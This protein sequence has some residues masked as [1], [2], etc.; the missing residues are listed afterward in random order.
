MRV[1]YHSA[2][3]S[4]ELVAGRALSV[5]PTQASLELR[6]D[7]DETSYQLRYNGVSID[8]DTRELP[9]EGRAELMVARAG[10]RDVYSIYPSF[11]LLSSKYAKAYA[12]FSHDF[13]GLSS[14]VV[15][16]I[17]RGRI[18]LYALDQSAEVRDYSG[19]FD[20]IEASF[21]AFKAICERP[22]SHLKS[23][24]EIRPIDAVKRVGYESIPYLAAHS[25]D[26]LARTASGLKPARLF[27]R[28]EED[29]FHIYENRLVKTLIDLVLAFLRKVE[30]ELR[31]QRDQLKGILDS[32]V[33]MESFGFDASFQKAVEELMSED[34]GGHE[35]RAES[36]RLID[37]L[38]HSANSLLKKYRT[39]RKTRL[40]RYLRKARP[41]S[42]PINSTN[43]L[44][45]DRHY[46]VVFKLWREFHSEIA[47]KMENCVDAPKY[48]NTC[49]DYRLYCAALCEY[50][51]HVLG[52][53]RQ[54]GGLYVRETDSIGLVVDEMDE[55]WIR[56]TLSDVELRV[57]QVGADIELPLSSGS[58]AYRFVINGRTLSWPNDITAG[59]IESFCGLFKDRRGGHRVRAEQRRKY[60]ALKGA[61]DDRQRFYG[62]PAKFSFVI[63]PIAIELSSDTQSSFRKLMNQVTE[64]ILSRGEDDF[65]VVALPICNESEQ[66]VTDY[67]VGES[68]KPRILPLSLF[69]IN[70]FR[71]L[72]NLLYGQILKMG[73]GGC[74]NCGEK[75]VGRDGRF[76]CDICYGLTLTHTT[77][78]NPSCGGTYD[79]L[80]YEVTNPETIE[81][82]GGVRRD[83]FF[84]W[85]SLFQYKN[86]VNMTVA[87]GKI[88][89]VC[90]YCRN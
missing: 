14:G 41:V 66:K 59:E 19:I 78:P 44:L 61:I 35:Y 64:R 53:S 65:V 90:P 51:A 11:G 9:C 38:Q 20:K 87:S 60:T 49:R 47:P 84:Q 2:F 86:I 13:N 88:R 23:V 55:G 6:P 89:A 62:D 46:S 67:A 29:D 26:W 36:Y 48:G 5:V 37:E 3:I 1:F 39:L 27:S 73:K 82:M 22:K 56:V 42:N 80:S 57:L 7:D 32:G 18:K 21:N 81:K 76:R 15:D 85:D 31:D 43:I 70:S 30:K 58:A 4:E 75:M 25:E 34:G 28:V 8:A 52:F 45:L 12:Q 50:T 83:D 77:C 17:L 74:P 10:R 33:R 24:N 71:R 69:D 63:V 72:Q 16:G 68:D 79:Y 40:Y 54:E